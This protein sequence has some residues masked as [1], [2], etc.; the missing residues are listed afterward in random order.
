[1]TTDAIEQNETIAEQVADN[2]T[3]EAIDQAPV[4]FAGKTVTLLPATVKL[5]TDAHQFGAKSITIADAQ[6]RVIAAEQLSK[7]KGWWN[8]I[9]AERKAAKEPFD[10]EAKRVQDYFK[11]ALDTLTTVEGAIK[12]AI[13]AFDEEQERLR[14]LAE[15]KAEEDA[16]KTREALSE[17]AE[18]LDAKGKVEQAE[19]VRENAAT[20]VAAPVAVIA[21]A[22]IKTKGT[23][24]RTNYSAEVMDLMELVL[25]VAAIELQKRSAGDP[26]KLMQIIQGYAR[27]N[28]NAAFVQADQKALD[29]MAKALKES[30]NNMYP[31][32]QLKTEKSL[33]QRAANPF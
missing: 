9:E 30:F 32:V 3:T 5:I 20:I 19:A 8:S 22:P 25:G 14:R 13:I 4:I 17:K 16:R 24:T 10:T 11:P 2:T 6:S 7:I 21:H 31:G 23:G 26:A 18:K 27:F 28:T 1:M 15:A 29:G 33:S 12:K